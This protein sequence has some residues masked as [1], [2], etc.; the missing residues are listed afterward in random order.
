MHSTT[1]LTTYA[2]ATLKIYKNAQKSF[3][4][5]NCNFQLT[6]NQINNLYFRSKKNSN[7]LLT[8]LSFHG[9]V[10]KKNLQRPTNI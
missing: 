7:N 5:I 1:I 9:N 6:N 2:C 4:Y 8:L 10:G 3:K